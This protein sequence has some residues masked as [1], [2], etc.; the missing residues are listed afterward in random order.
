[1]CEPRC[2]NE[3][4][5]GYLNFVALE[6]KG[7]V[8]GDI[9]L[10]LGGIVSFLPPSGAFSLAQLAMIKQKHSIATQLRAATR[11]FKSLFFVTQ[12]L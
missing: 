10:T 6:V 11:C 9:F 8:V 12:M 3:L 5:K 4:I 1:L 7:F 2:F